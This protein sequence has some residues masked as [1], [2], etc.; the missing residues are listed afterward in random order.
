MLGGG[1]VRSRTGI[2]SAGTIRAHHLHLSQTLRQQVMRFDAELL[3][4]G[5]GRLQN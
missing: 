2:V 4:C 1:M 5:A 3:H